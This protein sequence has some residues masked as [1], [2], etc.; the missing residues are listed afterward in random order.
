MVGGSPQSRGVVA[1]ASYEARVFG[2][3][4]AMPMATAVRQC[5]QGIIVRPR[6]DRYREMSRL[7]MDIFHQLTDLVE[8][9]SLDE[10]YL[11][12][13]GKV[14]EGRLPLGVAIELK[15]Q[16]KDATG[17]N[18]SVGV[19]T[20]KSVAKIASDLEKPD[21]LV[22]VAPGEERE[23]LSPLP[24][25]KLWGVGPKTAERL[26]ADGIHTIGDLA[27]QPDEWFARRFG[28]RAP[29]V[30]A[31]AMGQDEEP[32]K[33]ER[34]PKSI[35]A[36]TT[37][38]ED[39]SDPEELGDVLNRLALNV[40]SH[41]ERKEVKGRTVTVKLRLTDFTTLTRQTTLSTATNSEKVISE[42]GWKL[43]S[44]ELTPGRSLRLLGVGMS[45]FAEHSD[46]PQQ[47]P[48]PFS[49]SMSQG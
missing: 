40:S 42:T 2:V 21:G 25:G 16:V 47:L 20:S 39:I 8:P 10:A 1:T 46:L 30:L 28:K 35:S 27:Q 37:F 22:L 41:L 9:L 29:Y 3:H 24:V 13:T 38:P 5:P 14:A 34:T 45:G 4:S 26:Y 48:L 12:V 49:D 18:V 43:M 11:D 23:F 7:V 36:E 31:K 17:L 32:V 33:T 44:A 19:G 15:R 6:F